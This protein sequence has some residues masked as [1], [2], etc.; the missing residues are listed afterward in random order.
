MLPTTETYFLHYIQ[1][2]TDCVCVCIEH[3]RHRV[4]NTHV[5]LRYVTQDGVCSVKI[6][7]KELL[8]THSSWI[9]QQKNRIPVF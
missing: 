3:T 1:F 5:L 8:P 2:S 4:Q 6:Q 7:E 9:R